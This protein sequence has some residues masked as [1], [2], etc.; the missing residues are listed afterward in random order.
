MLCQIAVKN[1]G[2]ETKAAV[3]AGN[4]Y[5]VNPGSH[6]QA[7]T[8]KKRVEV[9]FPLPSPLSAWLVISIGTFS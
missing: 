6:L 5:Q 4:H 8:T 7:A 1:V 9:L 2:A 3:A